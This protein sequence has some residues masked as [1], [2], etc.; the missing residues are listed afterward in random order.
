MLQE[1][2]ENVRIKAPMVHCITN[3]VTAND[4]ANMILACGA[5]PIMADDSNEVEE[6]TA[7][8]Q[9]LN[10]NIGTLQ[11]RTVS[12]MLAAGRRANELKHPVL[13]DPVGVGASRWRMEMAEKLMK[14]IQLDVIRGNMS[15][16]KSLLGVSKG[17]GGVDALDSDAVT[18]QKVEEAVAFAKE[19]AEKLGCVLAIT[20]AIDLVTDGKTCYVIRGGRA[21]MS[22]VTGTGCQLSGM[23]TAFL[24]ANPE[25]ILQAAATAVC[26]MNVAGELAWEQ[27]R[28][29]EGNAT[30]RN[31]IIDAVYRMDGELLERRANYEVR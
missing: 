25:N 18:E 14:E 17:S 9:G 2:L 7:L 24:A 11:E 4:V 1:I 12:S 26:V 21:E 29:E 15:E 30:Y 8:S 13:L 6:I 20:G 5:K 22:H 16:I 3:Y 19:A 27:L 31:R 28:P 23:M 10:M